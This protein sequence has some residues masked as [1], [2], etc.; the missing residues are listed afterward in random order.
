[1]KWA[2]VTVRTTPEAS[3]GVLDAMLGIAGGAVQSGP[4]GA[5]VICAYVPAGKA[6]RL[7]SQVRQ[8][9]Q[10]LRRAGLPT[11]GSRVARRAVADKEWGRIWRRAFRRER[12]AAGVVVSPPWERYQAK[13]GE[14]VV[15]IGP[16]PAFGTGQHATTRMCLRALR[17]LLRRDDA[18]A[19]V[20]T[21][22]GILAIAAVKMGAKMAWAIDNDPAA[23]KS[24]RENARRNR[25]GKRLVIRRGDLLRGVHR[26]FDLIVANLTA[27]QLVEMAPASAQRLR[28]G[29]A[30]IGSGIVRG[31]VAAVRR[32]FV[33][34][35]LK[36]TGLLRQ[37]EWRTLMFVKAGRER[38]RCAGS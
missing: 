34:A 6:D 14:T 1:M 35:G 4:A 13:P 7:L 3:E 8:R 36:P 20:G 38:G 30:L 11:R 31:K 37:G 27:E 5:T 10:A 26:R 12:V 18:V 16:G 23:L 22:S 28:A 25:V 19:D 15:I 32:A 29:G 9:L 21:G 17:R 24:A 33:A 2:K